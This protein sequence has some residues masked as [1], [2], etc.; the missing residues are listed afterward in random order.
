VEL[1]ELS[2]ERLAKFV[3]SRH[4]LNKFKGCKCREIVLML[5]RIKSL[6]DYKLGCFYIFEA[7]IKSFAKP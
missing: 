2:L 5:A 1:A 6:Y 4:L 3:L 7:I